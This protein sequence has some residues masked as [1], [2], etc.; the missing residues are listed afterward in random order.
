MNHM[1]CMSDCQW[2]VMVWKGVQLKADGSCASC[3][4]LECLRVISRYESMTYTIAQLENSC[5]ILNHM[6]IA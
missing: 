3:A 5:A 2:S 1:N 4:I 6:I